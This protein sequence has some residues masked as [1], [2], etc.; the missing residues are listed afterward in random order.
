MIPFIAHLKIA[1]DQIAKGGYS[2]LLE[3]AADTDA[4]W[5]TKGTVERFVVLALVG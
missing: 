5:F 2:V 3:V 1:E 4:T